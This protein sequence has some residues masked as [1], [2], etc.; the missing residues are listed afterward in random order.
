LDLL[1]YSSHWDLATSLMDR[2]KA[3][4]AYWG[5]ARQ[6]PLSAGRQALLAG[7]GREYQRLWLVLDRT[8]EADPASTTERWLDGNAFRVDDQWLSPAMRVVRYE[9]A[10]DRLGAT[11]EQHL[12]LRLGDRLRLKGY[13]PGGA[14]EVQ[15]GK[16]LSFSLFWQAEQMVSEDYAVFVQL[17]DQDGRLRVQLDRQP[18]GGFRPTSTWQTGEMVRDNYGLELPAD[19]S[20]G[21]YQLITGLY[22]PASMARLAVASADGVPLGDFATLGRIKV[23]SGNRSESHEEGGP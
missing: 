2:Y 13:S 9:L 3:R 22:L 8:P 17:L 14:T 5:W 15:A 11:P 10:G 21:D 4:P 20:Q 12:D 19:L 18:V 6:E 16:V 7:M 1:A 23:L